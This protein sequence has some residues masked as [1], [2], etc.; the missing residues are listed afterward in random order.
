MTVGFY[1]KKTKK[2]RCQ[3]DEDD[4]NVLGFLDIS[5]LLV[6]FNSLLNDVPNDNNFLSYLIVCELN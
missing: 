5:Q 3:F 2:L 6:Y 4:D 1:A